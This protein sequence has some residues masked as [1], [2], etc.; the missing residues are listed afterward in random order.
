[1]T[2]QL[3][4]LVGLVALAAL[5]CNGGPRAAESA[6]A[7]VGVRANDPGTWKFSLQAMA[8][9]LLQKLHQTRPVVNRPGVQVASAPTDVPTRHRIAARGEQAH[10]GDGASGR[11]RTGEDARGAKA[12]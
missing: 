4:C 7:K 9:G 1:M 3:S 10:R 2:R 6:A 11:E 12:V 5:P 8:G